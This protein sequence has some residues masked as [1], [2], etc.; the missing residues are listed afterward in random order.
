MR[1]LLESLISWGTRFLTNSK[2]EPTRFRR[3][4]MKLTEDKVVLPK[5]FIYYTNSKKSERS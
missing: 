1:L 5:E 4:Y 2:K 3:T